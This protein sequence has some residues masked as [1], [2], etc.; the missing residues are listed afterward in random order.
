MGT[1]KALF[2]W[3]PPPPGP[4]RPPS[5]TALRRHSRVQAAHPR[6]VVVAGRNSVP[7]APRP[8]SGACLAGNP[9]PGPWSIQLSPSW[10][11]E[12]VSRGCDA[13][14]ITPVDCPPLSAASLDSLVL[15]RRAC[16]ALGCRARKR[17]QARPSAS[18]QSRTHRRLSVRPSPATRA[19]SFTPTLRIVYVSVPDRWSRPASIRRRLRRPRR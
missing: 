1:D 6:V 19:K 14:M 3:P 17:W 15:L 11:A 4:D 10:P 7:P 16:T 5:Q 2:P 12:A 18:R 13:A 9:D 8:S